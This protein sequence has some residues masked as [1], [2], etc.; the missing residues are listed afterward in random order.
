MW[1]QNE[2]RRCQSPVCSG[3]LW[4]DLSLSASKASAGSALDRGPG[5]SNSW[6]RISSMGKWSI[7]TVE[8]LC[9]SVDR[10][11]FN[12]CILLFLTHTDTHSNRVLRPSWAGGL[13]THTPPPSEGSGWFW[14]PEGRCYPLWAAEPSQDTL[15]VCVCVCVC[16]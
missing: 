9:R 4:N 6:S 10:P 12:C 2:F 1:R 14:I 15:W 11:C 3:R 5:S 8:T 16:V 13:V 7:N